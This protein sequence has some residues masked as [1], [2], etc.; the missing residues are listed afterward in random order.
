M[1][2]RELRLIHS[3][4]LELVGDAPATADQLRFAGM[5]TIASGLRRNNGERGLRTPILPSK[6][7]LQLEIRSRLTKFERI[8]LH[9]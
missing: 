4:L 3:T 5:L 9:A 7:R 1:I 2:S 6:E 8:A